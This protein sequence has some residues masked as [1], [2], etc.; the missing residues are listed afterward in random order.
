MNDQVPERIRAVAAAVLPGQRLDGARLARGGS[1]EVLLLPGTAVVRVARN[2]GA[3]AALPRRTELLRRL[4][5][6]DLPFAVPEP[7]SAVATVE[8]STGVALSWLYG[9]PSAKYQ[10]GAPKELAALL[11]VLREVDCAP[12]A[13]VLGV[14]HEYA[15]GDRWAG[16]MLDAVVPRLPRAWRR[17]G[18]RRIRAALDL[19]R[20]QPS[21]V[22]GDL[23][24]S[25]MHWDGR[26][27]L[28]GVLDWDLAQPFDPALDA[29]CLSWHGW[30]KV[31]AAVDPETLR[32]A[33]VWALT[34]GLEQ[35]AFALLNGE[36]E[37][38]LASRVVAVTEWLERTTGWW[39]H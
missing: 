38:Y 19:P 28:A 4:A 15:G 37:E 11:G 1:H 34:F 21:L 33:R 12:L 22:H 24:G 31:A 16:L 6:L 29:A 27:R 17:E 32:R 23:A 14:P 9:A 25:N 13:D 36:T 8:G 26:G 7:L 5:R 3:A 35:I 39:V 10:G 30:D 18:R 20:Q 2:P